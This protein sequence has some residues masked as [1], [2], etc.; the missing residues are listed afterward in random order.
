MD[1]KGYGKWYPVLVMIGVQFA[2]ATINVLLK[3]VIDDGLDHL[4]FITYRLVVATFF[5]VPVA[6]FFERKRETKLTFSILCHL[7]LN[8]IL[9]LVSKFTIYLLVLV[10]IF[11]S[12]YGC[13][14]SLTQYLFLLGIQ[15]T[16]A[17]FSCAFLNMVPV[18]TFII[19]LPFGLESV[20]IKS[21]GGRAKVIGTLICVGGAT[22]L[23]L[24]KG[25][26]L[27]NANSHSPTTTE[28]IQAQSISKLGSVFATK[29]AR[30]TSGS[31]ALVAGTILWSSW[32]IVQSNIGKRYPLQYSSTAIMMFFGGIQSF[33]LS[34]SIDRDLSKWILKDKLE[35]FSVLY[36]GIVG[37]GFCFVAMSWCV[38]KRGPVFSAAFSP[39]VQIIAAVF[40]IPFLHEPLHLGRYFLFT[41]YHLLGGCPVTFQVSDH[42]HI[43]FRVELGNFPK[44]WVSFWVGKP[45]HHVLFFRRKG[46]PCLV[47]SAIVVVGLYILLWGKNK[48]LQNVG[49]EKGDLENEKAK[50]QDLESHP[51]AVI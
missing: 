30:W 32:F 20:N 12:F 25:T 19:S 9:G 39:I 18:I 38:K 7:F 5:L 24:Y 10:S 13:R 33:A 46:D 21:N 1:T 47:G 50:V 14:A 4:V 45:C 16:S 3:K 34:L 49:V 36:A 37:S 48:E 23:T 41:I 29:K 2:F 42:G 26:P 43:L 31:L 35:I 15:Y 8:A 40:D 22:L 11:R 17:T 27:F 28:S 44:L 6:F 51:T